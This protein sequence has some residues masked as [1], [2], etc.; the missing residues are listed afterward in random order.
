MMLFSDEQRGILVNTRIDNPARHNFT[1][2]HELGHHFLDHPPNFSQDGQRSI[3]CTI[4]ETSTEQKGREAEANRF[5]A[6]LLMPEE[7]FG[8]LMTGAEIDFALIS[9]LAI[10]FMVSKQACSYRVMDITQKPCIVIF[11]KDGVITHYKSSRA[12]KGFIAGLQNIPEDTAAHQAILRK[13]Q[14]SN[15]VECDAAKWLWRSIPLQ[16][17]YEC[18]RGSYKDGVAMTILKW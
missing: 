16:K 12:A 13:S 15:F 11:T 4:S 7:T 5:A 18:T 2:A 10:E 14:Q 6:E 8:F 17:L 3:R 1:F 9:G